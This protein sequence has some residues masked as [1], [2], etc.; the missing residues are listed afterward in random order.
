MINENRDLWKKIESFQIDDP[1]AKFTFSQKLAKENNWNTAFTTR[2]IEEY[3]KFIYLCCISPTGASPSGTVDEVWH[4]HLTYTVNYWDELCGKTLGRPL[5]HH[6]SKG[7]DAEHHKHV[8]WYDDTLQLYESVFRYKP[9]SNIWPSSISNLKENLP[10]PFKPKSISTLLP[11]A[12]I[13][14]IPFLANWLFFNQLNPFNLVGPDFLVFFLFLS[15]VTIIN[16]IVLGTETQ[17][18]LS[19]YFKDYLPDD[20]NVFQGMYFLYGTH[21]ALQTAIL[22]LLSKGW[23][24]LP[25]RNYFDNNIRVYN[26]EGSINP[27]VAGLRKMDGSEKV[28]YETLYYSVMDFGSVQHHKLQQIKG[29]IRYQRWYQYIFLSLA[30]FLGVAR[31]V[32]GAANGKPVGYLLLMML[33]LA[34]IYLV[35]SVSFDC[36]LHLNNAIKNNM[37]NS[38]KDKAVFEKDDYLM[39]N[40]CKTG[41]GALKHYEEYAVVATMFAIYTPVKPYYSNGSDGSSGGCSSGCSGG[42]GCGGV[43]AEA[44]EVSTK[45][46]L[47]LFSS[48]FPI[49]SIIPTTNA[50]PMRNAR[51]TSPI[52][53]IN[54]WLSGNMFNLSSSIGVSLLYFLF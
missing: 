21:R 46:Y 7:G 54:V 40:F 5:H 53:S 12:L 22:D 23:L 16:L 39:H 36:M 10:N 4:L 2:A 24:T 20:I 30:V 37:V 17:K 31:V 45:N 1:N 6:P 19:S 50:L 13:Y 47:F 18:L 25:S 8:K 26:T 35:V 38:E 42:G 48:S 52:P 41:I 29:T 49:F 9:P 27:L 34:M 11:F 33:V 51:F 43:D 14:T 28:S 32:Q 3:K 15:V 44:V